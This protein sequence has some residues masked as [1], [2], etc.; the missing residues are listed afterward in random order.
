MAFSQDPAPRPMMLHSSQAACGVAEEAT[1]AT[2]PPHR[3]HAASGS[4]PT[5]HA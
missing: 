5:F 1:A 2:S 4:S 3:G